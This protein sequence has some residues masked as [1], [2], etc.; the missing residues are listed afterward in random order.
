MVFYF[1]R[2]SAK[3]GIDLE[4]RDEHCNK[5]LDETISKRCSGCCV[6]FYNNNNFKYQE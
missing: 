2:I 4:C 1:D 6:V 5:F 3:E